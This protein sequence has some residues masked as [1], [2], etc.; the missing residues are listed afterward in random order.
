MPQPK[1]RTLWLIIGIGLLLFVAYMSLVPPRVGIGDIEYSDLFLH[2]LAYGTIT[3]WFQQIFLQRG[4]LT[5]IA[6]A[7]LLYG[8]MLE[9]AQYFVPPREPHWSDFFANAGG[10]LLATLVNTTRIRETLLLFEKHYLPA[11]EKS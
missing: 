1:L 3:G 8:G 4:A 6:A 7:M 11:V 10:V 5:G 2:L 9:L